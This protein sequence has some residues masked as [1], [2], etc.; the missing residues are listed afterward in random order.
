MRAHFVMTGILLV[1]LVASA[2]VT[3]P[4]PG[5]GLPPATPDIEQRVRD[6]YDQAFLALTQGLPQQTAGTPLERLGII[7]E[8]RR[9][10]VRWAKL[11]GAS[12]TALES[13]RAGSAWM[14]V[15]PPGHPALDAMASTLEVRAESGGRL[16]I[17]LIKP[18]MVSQT[19]AAIFL[20]HELSH[21]LDRVTG[22][23][24]SEPTRE[25]FLLGELRAYETEL[26]AADFVSQGRISAAIRTLTDRWPSAA[27]EEI[28]GLVNR[29][30][31]GDWRNLDS[32]MGAVP[33]ESEAER[34]LRG[35][36]YLVAAALIH[37]QGRPDYR[38]EALK[39]VEL[40][41]GELAPA[42]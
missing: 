21:L 28:P 32:A 7:A 40:L 17:L 12:Y 10:W 2:C 20:V 30:G 22:L 27:L 16:H 38:E 3:A 4:P 8:F 14:V 9:D 15:V 1:A 13:A 31:E 41:Y 29:L 23:E 33:P 39:T 37:A 36:F 11:D 35:G 26:V 42:A 24:P 25:Q 34:G 6:R 18:Q 19:W 5:L